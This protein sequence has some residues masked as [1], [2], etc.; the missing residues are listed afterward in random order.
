MRNV[1]KMFRGYNLTNSVSSVIEALSREIA[2]VNIWHDE[3]AFFYIL[4]QCDI[5][6]KC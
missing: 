4:N 1:R 2:I 5:R 6:T 3:V